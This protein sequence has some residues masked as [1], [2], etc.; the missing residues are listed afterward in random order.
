M[1]ANTVSVAKPSRWRPLYS[2]WVC[3][4]ES[5]AGCRHAEAVEIFREYMMRRPRLIEAARQQLRGKNLACWCP[6]HKPCHA[7]VLIEIANPPTR[8]GARST[9]R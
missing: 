1:P 4:G 9:L 6:L 3:T 7:D 5:T 2:W 8:L